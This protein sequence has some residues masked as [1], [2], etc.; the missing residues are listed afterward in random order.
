MPQLNER[1]PMVSARDQI[2]R[3][4]VAEIATMKDK[5]FAVESALE[6]AFREGYNA[7]RAELVQSWAKAMNGE[8]S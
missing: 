3:E 2:V 6:V 7:A 5:D 8:P 1:K 4:L